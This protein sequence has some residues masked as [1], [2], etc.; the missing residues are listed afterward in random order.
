MPNIEI[1]ARCVNLEHA[2]HV[3]QKHKT[4]YLGIDHQL[5][6]YFNTM[7]GRMKLRESSLS[8][9]MLIPYL[10]QDQSGPKKSEYALLKVE[11]AAYLKNLLK[12]ILG[13]QA[14]VD[15]KREIFL[16]DNV[17]VH[18]DEVRDLGSFIEFEAVYYSDSPKVQ[19][20]EKNKVDVL[21]DVFGIH[22]ED[23]L[24]GSYREMVMDRQQGAKKNVC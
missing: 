23:L 22:K 24:D 14:V 10:R 12:N 4:D 11:D 3:A 9:A 19:Q 7:S 18:L 8:G 17:R 5:D 21:M 15:K 2:R 13:I 20:E 16:V 6:T 1:K